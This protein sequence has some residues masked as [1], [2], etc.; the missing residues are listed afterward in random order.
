MKKSLCAIA[1]SSL[2]LLSTHA[3][4]SSLNFSTNYDE[5]VSTIPEKIQNELPLYPTLCQSREKGLWDLCFSIIKD[6]DNRDEREYRAKYFK[7]RNTG[8]NPTF[9]STGWMVGRDFEF[10]F[11]DLAQSDLGLLVWDMPDD[12]DNH[13]HLMLMTFLPRKVIPSIQYESENKIKVTLPTEEVVVF[14]AVTKEIRSGVLKEGPLKT[15]SSGVALRPAITYQGTGLVLVASRVANYPVGD[16][17]VSSSKRQA[18]NNADV[19]YKGKTL[20]QIPV[21]DL[22]YTDHNKN[23][24]VLLKDPY[25]SDDKLIAFIEKKC[26]TKI[27]L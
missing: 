24:Q 20:C 8:G 16:E 19:I 21:K 1:L 25:A 9:P 13:G 7:V 5:T 11:E 4:Q 26:K 3:T 23:G 15:N 6:S 10:Q 18:R 22:W 2:V 27:S 14:D 12:Y 17:L